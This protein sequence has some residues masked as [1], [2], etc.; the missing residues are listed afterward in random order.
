ML[1]ETGEIVGETKSA[2]QMSGQL[3]E[4]DKLPYKDSISFSNG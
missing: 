4:G 1:A 3:Q 2:F